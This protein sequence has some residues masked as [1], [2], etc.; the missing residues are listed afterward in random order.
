MK[1]EQFLIS[2]GF[3]IWEKGGMKRIYINDLAVLGIEEI[4]SNPKSLRDVT[5]YYDC[6]SDEFRFSTTSSKEKVMRE[7]VNK[8]REDAK[9][10][11]EK[12]EVIKKEVVKETEKTNLKSKEDAELEKR[13]S[14]EK[15][16][17]VTI[18]TEINRTRAASKII[19]TVNESAETGCCFTDYEQDENGN[20]YF[21]VP[22]SLENVLRQAISDNQ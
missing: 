20:Y 11:A 19:K 5:F 14:L 2:K 7:L 16:Q 15:E 9:N 8:I 22:A 21:T 13:L 4:T 10:A 18:H 1:L 3:K 12:E 17:K 6:I